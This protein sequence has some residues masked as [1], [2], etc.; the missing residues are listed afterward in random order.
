MKESY[1]VIVMK[2]FRIVAFVCLAGLCFDC[3]AQ[4]GLVLNISSDTG[5]NV[6]FQ[7]NGSEA[8]FVFNNGGS[9]EG[10][11]I[12]GSS[13]VGDSITLQG[14]IGGTF[15]YTMASIVTSGTQQT[16]PVESS[17]GILTITDASHSSLTGTLA[18]VNVLTDGTVGGIDVYGAINLT[19][20]SYSG[21]NSDLNALKNG[22]AADGGIVTLSFSFAQ[23]ETLTSLAASGSNYQTGYSGTIAVVSEPTSLLLGCIAMGTTVLGMRWLGRGRPETAA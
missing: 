2:W 6:E 8:T 17:G 19:N 10:F 22:A 16:A 21:T 7:G 13:G 15:T 14:T 1:N 23:A 9:G 5:A 18:G 11:T 20:V 3:V 12:T 4:A